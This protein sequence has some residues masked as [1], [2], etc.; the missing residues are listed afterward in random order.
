MALVVFDM[1]KRVETPVRPE[2]KRIHPTSESQAISAVAGHS[3]QY[4]STDTPYREHH[5]QHQP[6][7]VAYVQDI[8]QP[9]VR[10]VDANASV[11]D[12][13]LLMKETG[14]HHIPVVDQQLKIQAILSERDLLHHSIQSTIKW[15]RNILEF[16]TH[17]VLCIAAEADIRQC[18]RAMMDYNIGAM[19]VLNEDHILTGIIT[20]T[21]I[22]RLISHYGPME[23]WA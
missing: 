16:A 1:G 10:W 21:D 5:A 12:A 18:A 3:V 11:A 8:M 19:P 13:W 7:P 17:P 14:F 22:I 6:Q 23:L 20:R 9:R 2:Q 15:H 4:G